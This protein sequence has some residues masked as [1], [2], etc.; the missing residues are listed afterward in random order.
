MSDASGPNA[1]PKPSKPPLPPG[2][3]IGPDGKPCKICTAWRNWKPKQ[4][5]TSSSS[6]SPNTPKKTTAAM[7]AALAS[8]RGLQNEPE[9]D[10]RPANCPPDVEQ[11]GA[12]TWTFLHTTAA[13]FPERPTPLQRANMLNLLHSLPA[14]YPCSHC[15]SHLG[16][17]MKRN[18]PD[19]SGRVGLSWWL[20]ERHN[21]VNERLG[22]EKFDCV[23]TDE[24]WRDGP[25]DG[26]CD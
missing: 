4:L 18:P 3:V 23:K 17:E 26:S 10:A 5:G 24:R 1:T 14:L 9:P 13:Y 2:M 12:A 20:C 15:A 19:V 16:E 21:E 6:S 11:L 7:M 25:P 8:G 22:K